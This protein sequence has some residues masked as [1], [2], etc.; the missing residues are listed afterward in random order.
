M[1]RRGVSTIVAV[2]LLIV[3]IVIAA[4]A[5]YYW[6]GGVVGGARRAV[7]LVERVE[8][9]TRYTF[10]V[11]AGA[12][13]PAISLNPMKVYVR[14]VGFSLVN[15]YR[16][17]IKAPN[18][19]VLVDYRLSKPVPIAPGDVRCVEVKISIVEYNEICEALDR[20]SY[21][22]F[23]VYCEGG[24][25]ALY[26]VPQYKFVRAKLT[27][28]SIVFN[29]T[30]VIINCSDSDGWW[31]DVGEVIEA[32]ENAASK[33]QGVEI[34]VIDSSENLYTL[35]RKRVAVGKTPSGSSVEADLHGKRA[36]VIDAHGE[37]LPLPPQYVKDIDGD[38][39]IEVCIKEYAN[40]VRNALLSEYW[41]FVTLVGA[42]LYYLSNK[43]FYT[44]GSELWFRYPNGTNV[45]VDASYAG[46]TADAFLWNVETDIGTL[47]F[48][49]RKGFGYKLVIVETRFTYYLLTGEV[50][51]A[52]PC[53][54]ELQCGTENRLAMSGK[55]WHNFYGD[56]E[57]GGAVALPAT[58]AVER[59]N[60]FFEADLPDMI[61]SARAVSSRNPWFAD[62]SLIEYLYGAENSSVTVP[63]TVLHYDDFSAD[64]IRGLDA[65]LGR[66]LP[67]WKAVNA[68][69]DAGSR[70]MVLGSGAVAVRC[71]VSWADMSWTVST[72]LQHADAIVYSVNIGD[73][74]GTGNVYVLLGN[75]SDTS[76]IAAVLEVKS[77]VVTG[78]YIAPV[79]VDLATGTVTVGAGG[80]YLLTGL[81]ITPP[82]NVKVHVTDNYVKVC[83]GD[84][85]GVVDRSLLAFNTQ[86][87]NSQVLPGLATD[88]GVTA[89]I[90]APFETYATNWI[91]ASGKASAVFKIGTGL[92]IHAGYSTP[93]MVPK[94]FGYSWSDVTTKYIAEIGIYYP[95]YI[96]LRNAG[97]NI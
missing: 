72:I 37:V 30:L 65:G 13:T 17:V 41:I 31:V 94:E 70:S 14:N 84:Q 35:F 44:V 45:E 46:E 11:P 23:M 93:Y 38:G 92:Y 89:K 18:G 66:T 10:I 75:T 64:S 77:G 97:I 82:T 96:M 40:D 15:V 48:I 55:S 63:R 49:V 57:W 21:L 26:N 83:I 59:I 2:S 8:L 67:Y 4:I 73:L 47:T 12:S 16:V 51:A 74:S 68:Y 9:P 78:V 80:V 27:L 88:P 33:I 7:V 32:A 79:S 22:I 69:I 36:I 87:D 1:S 6:Y 39:L 3:I 60:S 62:P 86:L 91:T 53:W 24:E 50:G 54:E 95:L 58:E 81:S 56:R 61:S 90:T 43:G 52:G 20:W 28:E 5:L 29:V 25:V 85:C 76:Y 71:K 19:T 34:V 42:P